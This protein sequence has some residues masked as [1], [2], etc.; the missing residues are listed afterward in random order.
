MALIRCHGS[1]RRLALADDRVVAD[2]MPSALLA[3]DTVP[4]LTAALAVAPM[5][6]KWWLSVAK[7]ASACALP[8]I[9][10]QSPCAVG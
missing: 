4:D 8:D 10:A 6:S 9:A 3:V 2:P 1:S 5:R 7:N